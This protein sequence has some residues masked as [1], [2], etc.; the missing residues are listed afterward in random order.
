MAT[1]IETA[2][3]V[4]KHGEK[5]I[6]IRIRLWTDGIADSEDEIVPKH[7]S[8]SGVVSLRP[9]KAHG[10]APAKPVPFNSFLDLGSVLEELLIDHEIV[11]HP[12]T[13]MRKYVR[14]VKE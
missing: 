12:S 11:L 8:M 6:E 3:V 10:I 1:K 7:A 13:R 9:N 5:M 2:P 4:A 14:A